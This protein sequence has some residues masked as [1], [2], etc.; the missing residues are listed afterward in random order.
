TNSG[1][2]ASWLSLQQNGSAVSS[3]QQV[4]LTFNASAAGLANNT[5]YQTSVNVIPGSGGSVTIPVN[6][7]VGTC[8]G[9]PGTSGSMTSTLTNLTFGYP[10]GTQSN[11]VTIGSTNGLTTSYNAS[12]SAGNWLLLSGNSGLAQTQLFSQPLSQ[13]MTIYL[14]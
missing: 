13:P 7:C 6:F 11:I 14:N 8:S 12:V 2:T 1:S 5:L 10:S 9:N 4:T 3:L